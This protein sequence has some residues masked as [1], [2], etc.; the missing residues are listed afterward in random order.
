[1]LM[2]ID[3]V[4]F[5]VMNFE[6]RWYSLAYITASYFGYYYGIRLTQGK[7][8]TKQWRNIVDSVFLTGI[9]GGRIGHCLLYDFAYCI[10]NP[11]E[12]LYIHHGGMSFFGGIVGGLIGIYM[13]SRKHKC[14]YLYLTDTISML[15][16]FGLGIGRIANLINSE[17]LGKIT[18]SSF[19]IIFPLIDN[20]H[21][22][23][24]QIIESICEGPILFIILYLTSTKNAYRTSVFLILYGLMRFAIEPLKEAESSI[25]TVNTSLILSLICIILGLLIFSIYSKK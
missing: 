14:S 25:F 13:A 3:P 12:I 4:A 7:F 24:S 1:M 6:I 21:R 18:N 10:Q 17:C 8:T 2:N 19:Y 16:P 22:Y 20:N 11:I 9:I 23:P 5:K 15:I